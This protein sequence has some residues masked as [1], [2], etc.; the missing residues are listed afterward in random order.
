MKATFAGANIKG[1]PSMSA[2]SV[3][4]DLKVIM[5]HADVVGVQEFKWSW[6]WSV[7]IRLLKK[8]WAAYPA[9]DRSLSHPNLGA[10]G[11]FWKRKLF[12]R[13][14]K[15]NLPAFDFS[16]DNTGIMNNRWIRA[17]LLRSKKDKFTAWFLSTHFVVGGDQQHD[18][19][20]RKEFMRQNLAHFDQALTTLVKTGYPIMGEL[21][22]NIHKN[23][24]AYNR[25]MQIFAKHNA[26]IHGDHGIEYA[27][28]INGSR[29]TFVNVKPKRIP[30][31]RL[32]TDH[33]T[34]LLQ[35]EGVAK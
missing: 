3:S 30:T 17:V 11:L 22:A 31:T 16:Y 8:R 7:A 4:H 32:K 2:K 21:D 13:V 5:K 28:H 6:Y 20:N 26:K 25:L 23:T 1:T 19:E 15:F 12:T 24:W 35:W 14:H 18:P 29:G 33:E 34:R 10:Q 9:Y 27:F